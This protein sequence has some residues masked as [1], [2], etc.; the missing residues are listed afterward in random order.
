MEQ[1]I[2]CGAVILLQLIL[3]LIIG[4]DLCRW[5]G[6]K[7]KGLLILVVGFFGYF[8]L[9]QLVALP[10]IFL[11]I[12]FHVLVIVWAVVCVLILLKGVIWNRKQLWQRFGMIK[13]ELSVRQW[14]LALAALTLLLV[15]IFYQ[16]I[17]YYMGFDT[18]FYVGTINTTLYT[19]Q[20]YVY[21]GETGLIEKYLDMRYAL[22]G[23]Y[24]S[25]TFWCKIF[26]VAPI[27]AQNYGMGS[28]C[29]LMAV[30]LM[31]LIG[32]Q[33][34]KDDS[35]KAYLYT[36][37]VIGLNCLFVSG[38]TTADFLLYRNSE[39]KGF[40]ANVV[41]AA[42][43]YAIAALWSNIEKRENWRLLFIIAAASVPV[44]MPAILIVPAIIGIVALTECLIQKKVRYLWYGI[45][46]VLPNVV[47]LLL[48]FLYTRKIWL[49]MVE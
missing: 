4:N 31:F 21:D 2:A 49:I 27:I 34:F 10:L 38:Y 44:S 35:R 48:Y 39:S 33:I 6:L 24:M 43:F 22:S 46:C 12:S 9:F 45:L 41:I 30:L 18:A 36:G 25:T 13:Q 1:L 42:V 14:Y 23:F 5:A 40:C 28:I 19:D 47:Y 32:K 11:K 15:L 8:G 20:M 29:M 37:I 17:H 3:Y 7:D 16:C 26:G